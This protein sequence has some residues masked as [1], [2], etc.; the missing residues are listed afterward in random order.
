MK[1]LVETSARHVHITEEQLNILFGEGHQL[2]KKKDLSQ[3]GQFACEERVKVVGPK[4]EK[5]GI[6][7]LGPVRPAAQ[8]EL[9][10]TDA[11]SLGFA[12]PVRESGC[13]EGTPGCKLVGPCGEVE[14][15]CG[16]VV[17]KRH[18]HL[19][20]EEAA[21]FGL[22]DK[23]VVSVKVDSDGRSII[24]GDVVVRVNPKF[25]AAM[26]IDTDESNAGGC[27][28]EVYGEIIVD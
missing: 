11:R 6:S 22:T 4:G 19:S 24:F 5:G 25:A 17:A 1:I 9:S 28:G 21:Q 8:V 23:Q 27:S 15:D 14:I 26:H 20:T 18:I 3:P 7:I 12:A 2:T 13:L 16:V 10:M